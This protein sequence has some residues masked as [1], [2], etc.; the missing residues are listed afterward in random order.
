MEK[1]KIIRW[2]DGTEVPFEDFNYE[3]D[4]AWKSDDFVIIY[5]DSDEYDTE[6][7]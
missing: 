3:K 5:I 7:N 4:W 2:P 1:I 6:Q